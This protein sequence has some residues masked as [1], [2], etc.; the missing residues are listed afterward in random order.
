MC[1]DSYKI[2]SEHSLPEHLRMMSAMI[3][4]LNA[5]CNILNEEQQIQITACFTQI[6]EHNKA[7]FIGFTE[8]VQDQ[9]FWMIENKVKRST[10]WLLTGIKL[11]TSRSIE[12]L[13]P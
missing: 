13:M 1:F 12:M 3:C 6:L 8:M 5:T 4:D 7:N 9:S 10:D 11:A 2:D